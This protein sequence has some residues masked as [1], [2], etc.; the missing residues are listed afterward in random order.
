MLLNLYFENWKFDIS[1]NFNKVTWRFLYTRTEIKS[2]SKIVKF[3][4]TNLYVILEDKTD[5]H[6]NKNW[7]DVVI[8]RIPIRNLESSYHSSHQHKEDRSGSQHSTNHQHTLI[9][10]VWKRDI[11]VDSNSCFVVT[12][13]I[14]DV[15]HCRWSPTSS[16]G[17]KLS[18]SF[19]T[20][21][22]SIRSSTVFYPI[23]SL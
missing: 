9:D 4:N 10:D 1:Q 3:S 14:H 2:L 19:R 17:V 11:V 23:S 15:S 16:L 6:E 12:K 8:K 7:Y 18:E 22:V 13:Q 5:Y 21:S 20:M